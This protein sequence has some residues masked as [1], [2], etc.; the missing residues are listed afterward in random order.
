[1]PLL[2][3]ACD[4]LG[5]HVRDGVVSMCCTGSARPRLAAIGR[6]HLCRSMCGEEEAGGEAHAEVH[7]SQL[8][9]WS[10][11]TRVVVMLLSQKQV[12]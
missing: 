9:W 3:A 4:Q 2:H 7:G 5:S 8:G 10:N 1:M 6:L 12:G 11:Q